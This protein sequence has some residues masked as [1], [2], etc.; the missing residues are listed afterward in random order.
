[1]II[2]SV[3]LFITNLCNR[4]CP[5][6]DVKE[7]IVQDKGA[8]HHLSLKEIDRIIDW[9]KRSNVNAV[10]LVGGEP[11]LHPDVVEIVKRILKS[12]IYIRSILTNGLVETELYRKITDIV[13]TNW[14]VNV[15]NPDTYS[16]EEWELLNR[17]LEL[18]RWKD[19]NK[20]I[21]NKKFDLRNLSLQL[22]ITFYQPD[23]RYN[24]IIE[25]AKKLDVAFIRYDVSHPS[26][27]TSNIYVDFEHLIKVK[28]VLMRFL[29]ECVHEGIKPNLDCVLPPCIFTPEEMRF[30][31]LF[32]GGKSICHPCLDLM[33]DLRVVYC[34][35]MRNALPTYSIQDMSLHEIARRQMLD[36]GKLRE[37]RPPRCRNCDNF[38]NNPTMCQGYCLRYKVEEA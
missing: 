16:T 21:G 1:M 17:N 35:S 28:P 23:Q 2:N 6:C 10:Q 4:C 24:Y 37:H 29:R 32:A 33:P 26:S 22:A 27:D 13:S 36:A 38:L 5:Y 7:W 30:I 12:R 20:L 31:L 19:D 8:A 15:N 34:T 14:L 3:N 9:L 25:M 18:L 11:M